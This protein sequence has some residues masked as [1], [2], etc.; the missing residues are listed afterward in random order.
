[1]D[2]A[3]TISVDGGIR[4]ITVPWKE[5]TL[6]RV[7]VAIMDTA[8][9]NFLLKKKLLPEWKITSSNSRLRLKV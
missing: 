4:V 1:M 7:V 5:N 3:L 8:C 2:T 6:I 9:G